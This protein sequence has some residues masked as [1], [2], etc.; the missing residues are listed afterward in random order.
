MLRRL[1]AADRSIC[2]SWADR[3]GLGT[4]QRRPYSD[5]SG[6]ERR[7]V[8]L[9]RALAQEPELLL[10]D[11]PAGHLDLRWQEELTFLVERLW[12]DTRVSVV[13]VTHEFRHVP[14]GATRLVLLGQGRVLA[15]G[16]DE[17]VLRP[18]VLASAFGVEVEAVRRGGRLHLLPRERRSGE[19]SEKRVPAPRP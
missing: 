15:S 10:L 17:D 2:A 12:R 19:A 11:E 6:G 1:S 7:K 14:A 3:L 9:A 4:L 5:L 16:S 18:D 13:M 8:H